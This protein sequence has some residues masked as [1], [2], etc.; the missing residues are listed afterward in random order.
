MPAG[1]ETDDLVNYKVV[2]NYVAANAKSWW[3]YVESEA[4]GVQNDNVLQVVTGTDKVS[5]WGMATFE[6]V[7]DP[8]QFEFQDEDPGTESQSRTYKWSNIISGRA[9]PPEEE[10]RDLWSS[11]NEPLCNQCVFVRTLNVSVF[12]QVRDESA[13]LVGV[14]SPMSFLGLPGQTAN[15]KSSKLGPPVSLSSFTGNKVDDLIRS[16][17]RQN[18]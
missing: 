9:G 5:S 10:I 15:P 17:I 8:I 6:N 13:V 1:A 14:G 4:C 7:D 12:D 11:R 3:E 2:E 18:Y 16:L